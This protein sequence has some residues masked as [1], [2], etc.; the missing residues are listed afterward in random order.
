MITSA[1]TWIRRCDRIVERGFAKAHLFNATQGTGEFTWTPAGEQLR[2]DLLHLFD[3][4]KVQPT[5]LDPNEVLAIV[6]LILFTG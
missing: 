1:E 6:S 5:D 2:R 3:V 4:P